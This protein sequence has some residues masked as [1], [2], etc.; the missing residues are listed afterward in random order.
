MTGWQT[1]REDDPHLAQR[2]EHLLLDPGVVLVGTTRRDGTPRLSP[3]E[4]LLHDGELWLCMMLHSTKARDL[5]RD[6]RV[7]VHNIVTSKDGAG[8]EFKVRG[9]VREVT[10]PAA[11]RRFAEEVARRL[12]WRAEPGWSHLFVVDVADATFLR[13]DSATGDQYG[14]RWP[15]GRRWLRRH[16]SQTSVGEP[17]P[18]DAVF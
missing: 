11:Q 3:V 14:A 9:T 10:D 16:T 15:G 1:L 5:L 17:E 12:G 6:P 2:G 18:T 7:L 13:Y 4:P 8:G